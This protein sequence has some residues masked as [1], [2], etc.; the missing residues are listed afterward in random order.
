MDDLSDLL[1]DPVYTTLIDA[2][3][4]IA[5]IQLADPS[6][7]K[8]VEPILAR[9]VL[10]GHLDKVLPLNTDFAH[11]FD[12]LSGCVQGL[13]KGKDT[14]DPKVLDGIA[15]TPEF[16]DAIS[17]ILSTA[18]QPLV[19]PEER[20]ESIDESVQSF[21]DDACGD[22]KKLFPQHQV[23]F[24]EAVKPL[25]REAFQHAFLH[26]ATRIRKQYP[27]K[28]KSERVMDHLPTS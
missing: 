17:S 22:L 24:A 15:K 27:D 10:Q 18:A 19:T 25:Y 26:H 1:E 11:P 5:K 20:M 4:E 2:S 9:K 23:G 28:I 14:R 21:V 8:T 13:A 12:K 7:T 16:A 3:L 6:S